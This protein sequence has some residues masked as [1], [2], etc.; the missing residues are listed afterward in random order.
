MRVLKFQLVIKIDDFTKLVPHP[1]SEITEEGLGVNFDYVVRRI[2]DDD[3]F[4][5]ELIE[6][7]SETVLRKSGK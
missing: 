4:Y 5:W 3:K 7:P 2:T 1:V 6:R